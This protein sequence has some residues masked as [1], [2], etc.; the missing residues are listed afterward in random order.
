MWNGTRSTW[1]NNTF[2]LF[3]QW[4]CHQNKHLRVINTSIINIV[5]TELFAIIGRHWIQILN[6]PA[7]AAESH[8]AE[9]VCKAQAWSLQRESCGSAA[10][11][12]KHRN[13]P[14]LAKALGKDDRSL[15]HCPYLYWVSCQNSQLRKYQITRT[16]LFTQCNW[17]KAKRKQL[18]NT[19]K[20]YCLKCQNSV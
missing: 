18:N 1:K 12:R 14:S 11:I 13:E 20:G 5:K 4:R 15:C 19:H 16:S 10:H 7:D 2:L 8:Q 17:H 6:S 3:S 9:K